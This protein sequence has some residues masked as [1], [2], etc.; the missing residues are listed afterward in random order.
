MI[1]FPIQ[2]MCV[3]NILEFQ[4]IIERSISH[5]SVRPQQGTG[6]RTYGAR[7]TGSEIIFEDQPEAHIRP[8]VDAHK[9]CY[10][11]FQLIVRKQGLYQPYK[12]FNKP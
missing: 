6:N 11:T 10:G 9:L 1:F 12:P 7:G 4:K 5:T 2:P 3:P 8:A